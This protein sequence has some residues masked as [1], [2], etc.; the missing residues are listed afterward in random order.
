MHFKCHLESQL[1]TLNLKVKVAVSNR[2]NWNAWN[3]AGED[4]YIN[5]MQE[6]W[7]LME[8]RLLQP[9]HQI[10]A[11]ITH[12]TVAY[13]TI[14]FS[15][16]DLIPLRLQLNKTLFLLKP[17][18]W[19]FDSLLLLWWCVKLTIHIGLNALHKNSTYDSWSL[20]CRFTVNESAVITSLSKVWKGL[21]LSFILKCNIQMQYFEIQQI[22]HW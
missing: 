2:I 1:A 15:L 3:Q 4:L 10:T 8:V 13:G 21:L 14:R 19:V 5:T 11:D 20:K 17:R 16:H 12:T 7:K 6:T 18:L 22:H 9:Q